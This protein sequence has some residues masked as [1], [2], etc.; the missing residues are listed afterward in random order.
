MTHEP[1]RIYVYLPTDRWKPGFIRVFDPRGAQV[2]YDIPCRGKAANKD[3]ALYDNPHRDPT[4]PYG[5]T[6]SGLYRPARVSAFPSKHR[7]F[8][9]YAILLE[10]Q[11]GDALKAM[12]NGRTGLAIHGNRGDEH[13]MATYGCIR[14]FDR[15]MALL[16]ATIDG[17]VVVEVFDIPNWPDFSGVEV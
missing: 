1:F 6:P 9:H 5:D 17:P 8:G 10:G 15:D 14:V 13:L 2:L 3:A 7:T 12:Q 4:K 16:N 11:T